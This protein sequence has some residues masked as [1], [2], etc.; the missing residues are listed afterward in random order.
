MQSKIT[1]SI[2]LLEVFVLIRF[3]MQQ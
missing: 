2:W 3:E 1:R